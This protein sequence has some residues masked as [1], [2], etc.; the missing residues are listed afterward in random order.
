MLP[1]LLK[2]IY[3]NFSYKYDLL[4]LYCISALF[5][6]NYLS[7]HKLLINYFLSFFFNFLVQNKFLAKK[8]EFLVVKGCVYSFNACIILY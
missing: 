5:E 4:V 8:I 2:Q 1:I 3:S 7:K 6:C